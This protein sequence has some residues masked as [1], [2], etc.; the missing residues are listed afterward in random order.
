MFMPELL[1]QEQLPPKRVQEQLLLH[2]VPEQF[3]QLVAAY[4]SRG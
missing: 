4:S 1:L 3:L 2:Q